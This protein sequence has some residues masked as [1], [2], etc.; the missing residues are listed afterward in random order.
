MSDD[1]M[2]RLAIPQTVSLRESVLQILLAQIMTGDLAPGEIYSVAQFA[3]T[4]KVSPTPIREAVLELANKNLLVIHKNRGFSVPEVTIEELEELHKIR[5]LL[6]VPATVEAGMLMDE[7]HARS[8][9]RI[10]KQ[11]V[12]AAC[13]DDLVSYIDVDRRFHT[14]FLQPLRMPHLTELVMNYRDRARLRGLES[15][16]GSDLLIAAS[17]QHGEMVE[18]SLAKDEVALKRIISDH[19]QATRTR[20]E[21]LNEQTS[22]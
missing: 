9:E 5:L 13:S 10:A 17:K 15:R 11:T 18:A 3:T 6:E 4:L 14:A 21:K 20:W 12:Q 19:I 2:G 7:K 1:M 8:V 16:L 22:V